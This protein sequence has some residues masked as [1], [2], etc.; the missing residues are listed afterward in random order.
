MSA[1]GATADPENGAAIG[2]GASAAY[3]AGSFGTGVFSTVPTVILLYYCTEVLALPVVW[4]TII[5]LIPKVW[6]ILWDPLVGAWS[7]RTRTRIGRRR[8]FM[9]VGTLGMTLTFVAMFSP[10]ALGAVG[11]ALWVGTTYFL[12]ATVY[13]LFA[14][15]YVAI[16]A[17]LIADANLRARLI[18]WRMVAVMIGILIGAG[19]VPWLVVIF[20]GGR[21]GYAAMSIWIAIICGIAM[22]APVLMLRGRDT[23]LL[24]TSNT[25]AGPKLAIFRRAFR[26]PVFKRLCLAYVLLLTASGAI[27][28]TAP[29]L[30]TKFFGRDEGSI[31]T[32]LLLMLVATTLTVMPWSRSGGRHGESRTLQFALSGYALGAVLVCALALAGSPWPMALVGFILLGV[33]FAAMQVLPY[34]MIASLIRERGA[35]DGAA[36]GALTGLWT[37]TEKLGLAL[38]PTITGLSLWVAGTAD[39]PA[40]PIVAAVSTGTLIVI[41]VFVLR[42]TRC[43]AKSRADLESAR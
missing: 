39:N 37:A 22:A 26:D 12:L 2:I 38:G 43:S 25:G 9:I 17:E 30:I 29:Y 3:A 5:V 14:V 34:T 28:S 31:G 20:G 4:A 36:E 19:L 1:P 23:P 11:T 21:Q 32:A 35:H 27:T 6:S 42:S 15:P 40:M 41:S 33:P 10:P 16:P 18:A 13:S 8:P 7:D 24:P